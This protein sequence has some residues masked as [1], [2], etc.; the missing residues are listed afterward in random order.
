MSTITTTDRLAPQAG[1]ARA[2]DRFQSRDRPRRILIAFDNPFDIRETIEAAL[3]SLGHTDARVHLLWAPEPPRWANRTLN[4]ALMRENLRYSLQRGAARLEAAVRELQARGFEASWESDEV[5]STLERIMATAEQ[6]DADLLVI[7]DALAAD[8][9]PRGRAREALSR[10]V[11]R[12]LMIIGSSDE[13]S[14]IEDA[15]AA[16]EPVSARR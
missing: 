12:P 7:P 5:D 2:A 9:K 8:L 14:L 3:A 6:F 10:R 15:G 1:T 16:R 13:V 4:H 11:G